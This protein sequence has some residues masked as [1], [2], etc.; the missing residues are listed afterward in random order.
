MLHL[1]NCHGEW[2][3]LMVAMDSWPLVG[4]YIRS[5]LQRGQNNESGR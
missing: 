2:Q 3:A 5:V 1:L 4:P